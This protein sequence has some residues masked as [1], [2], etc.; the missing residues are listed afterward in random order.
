M[1]PTLP[2]P[3]MTFPVTT[4]LT[5][6]TI[7]LFSKGDKNMGPREELASI[8]TKLNKLKEECN[9]LIQRE[10]ELRASLNKEVQQ[11]EA[12]RLLRYWEIISEDI[13]DEDILKLVS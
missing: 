6:I 1:V 7:R 8:A 11:K 10:T 9:L 4:I 5:V 3:D 12:L 2:I 13:K